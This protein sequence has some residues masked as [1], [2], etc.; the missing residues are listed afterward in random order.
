MGSLINST[1]K[2]YLQSIFEHV[3][4][5]FSRPIYYY[6]EA[7]TLVLNTNPEFNPIYQQNGGDSTQTI[8]KVVQ[9]GSFNARIQYDT[10]KSESFVSSHEID[11]Q[12]KLR[13][14]DGYVRLKVD[15]NGLAQLRKTKRLEF[16]SRRFSVES[17]VRPHGLFEPS[18]YTFF[19]LP[20]DSTSLA[21]HKT[22]PS[23]T[24]DYKKLSD[25]DFISAI[26][27]W[28]LDPISATATYGPI[29]SWDVSAVTTMAQAFKG[30]SSFNEDISEWNVS[31]V[32]NMD[33]MFFD[34]ELFNQ[35]LTSWNVA[36][37]S[38]YIDFA[39]G[40]TLGSWSQKPSF[41]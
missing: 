5:T 11:S 22:E 2:N 26:D 10:D 18:Y 30:R 1:Q 34:A 39:G 3:H 37:V 38:S 15:K 28:H 6:K 9:S 29:G 16:D 20:V 40:N 24:D 32:T 17:D 27:L 23:P 8:K 19:L 36:S 4:D 21:E 12:L 7:K 33:E 14:P 31:S 41:I 35:N 25:R 13:V